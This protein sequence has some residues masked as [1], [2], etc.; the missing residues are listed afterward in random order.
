MQ[1]W[2]FSDESAVDFAR[3]WLRTLYYRAGLL[4][5]QS[6]LMAVYLWE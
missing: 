5:Y 6:S 3:T 2:S 4:E 1:C